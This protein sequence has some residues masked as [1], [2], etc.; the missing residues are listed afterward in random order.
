MIPEDVGPAMSPCEQDTVTI[1][2]AAKATLSGRKR[3][4]GILILKGKL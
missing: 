3:I 2:S 1:A 4:R